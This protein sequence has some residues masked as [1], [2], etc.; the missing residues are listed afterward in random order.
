[1]FTYSYDAML[2]LANWGSRQLMFRFPRT[3]VDPVRTRQYDVETMDYSSD[4]IQ[5]DI[6]G[7]HAILN[8]QLNEEEGL[9]WIEGEGLTL[10]YSMSEDALEPP[11]PSGLDETLSL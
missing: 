2:Y 7:E 3:L 4:I 10:T 6:K 9:G 1:V 5:V 8:I 11:V